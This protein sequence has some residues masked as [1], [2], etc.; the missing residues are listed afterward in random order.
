MR[1][2]FVCTAGWPA[3][4][5]QPVDRILPMLLRLGEYYAINERVP[6]A[7]REDCAISFAEAM[8]IRHEMLLRAHIEIG[9]IIWL[10]SCARNHA[11]LARRDAYRRERRAAGRAPGQP[12]PITA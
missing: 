9:G 5:G 10:S 11:R 2:R 12:L 7:E 4:S 8:L 1:P 6:E 3:L